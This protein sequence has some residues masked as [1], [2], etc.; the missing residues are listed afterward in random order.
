MT[1]MPKL[2]NSAR[3][4]TRPLVAAMGTSAMFPVSSSEPATTTRI[5]PRL[6]TVPVMNV[7]SEPQG[8]SQ[9]RRRAA[10]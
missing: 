6:A 7:G 5:S 8:P 4:G 3:S 2:A 1:T 9:R 10:R